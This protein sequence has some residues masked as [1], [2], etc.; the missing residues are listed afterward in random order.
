MCVP[1]SIILLAK[2]TK[3][4]LNPASMTIQYL[5]CRA[6]LNFEVNFGSNG[7]IITVVTW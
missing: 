7:A 2:V 6:D 1:R 5:K 3:G 4:I